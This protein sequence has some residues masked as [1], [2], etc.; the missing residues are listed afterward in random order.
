MAEKSE[1]FKKAERLNQK[2]AQAKAKYEAL[3]ADKSK[4]EALRKAQSRLTAMEAT[5]KAD[6]EEG[7]APTYDKATVD[8]QK[9][10]VKDAK[11]ALEDYK[12]DLKE[13][14]DRVNSR[15]SELERIPGMREYL[16]DVLASRF[17]KSIKKSQAELDTYKRLK[18][19]MEE[20]PNLQATIKGIVNSNRKISSLQSK[21]DKIEA[22]PE[23]NRTPEQQQQLIDATN[24]LSTEKGKL[25]TKTS[26]INEFL[27]KKYPDITK[28]Q[29]AIIGELT[30]ADIDR[31]IAGKEKNINHRQQEYEGV[32][33][34]RLEAD[35]KKENPQAG[36]SAP[37]PAK[38]GLWTRFKNWVKK[39][40]RGEKTELEE[41]SD[42]GKEEKEEKE[43][44]ARAKSEFRT[45][46]R[47]QDNNI[48]KAYVDEKEKEVKT[49]AKNARKK[50]QEESS[51]EDDG[52]R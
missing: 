36:R 27:S 23:A 20:H 11:E 33:G 52:S 28:E 18:E 50:M 37:P 39:A 26:Q 35:A 21:I 7:K 31:A 12:E 38:L 2:Y 6:M 8:A 22:I 47:V 44:P 48:I 29:Q 5:N 19:I 42:E 32:T 30:T 49:V 24:E 51:K 9:Q 17:E 3:L 14:L 13:A 46:Y 15:L 1:D 25:A 34:H 41:T 10:V 40:W 16:Q 43:K 45:L 4:E